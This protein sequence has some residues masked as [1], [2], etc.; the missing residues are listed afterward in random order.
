MPGPSQHKGPGEEVDKWILCASKW[1]SILGASIGKSI[2]CAPI[3]KGLIYC[4]D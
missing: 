2:F 3:G 1:K 4:S